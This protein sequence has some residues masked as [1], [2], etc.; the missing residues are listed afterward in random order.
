MTDLHNLLVLWQYLIYLNIATLFI[1]ICIILVSVIIT[2][3]WKEFGEFDRDFNEFVGWKK[4]LI[5]SGVLK[6]PN[7]IIVPLYILMP[8]YSA[9]QSA[10]LLIK[11]FRYGLVPVTRLAIFENLQELRVAL[12]FNETP[13]QDEK[14]NKTNKTD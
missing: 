5:R 13:K 6:K 3:E 14:A 11:Y 10:N 12:D 1:T 4:S 8:F 9:Y 2:Q 7:L